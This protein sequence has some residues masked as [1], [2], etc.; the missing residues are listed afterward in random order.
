MEQSDAA[1]DTAEQP[2]EGS[3]ISARQIALYEQRGN[4]FG[5]LDLDIDAGGVTM[6]LAAAGVRRTTLL[7]ALCG[8]MR[9]SSGALTVLGHTDDPH[10]LF[11]Q[12]AV[13]CI[14]E[15]DE[16]EQAVTVK[17]VI[18][19]QRRWNASFFQWVPRADQAALESM[20]G[21]T[22]G[23][24]P[25]PELDA[26]VKYLPIAQQLL[27]K[28]AIANV[29]KPPLLVV[30]RIDDT[31]DEDQKQIL[32]RL[33]ELGQHQ[34]IV[35]GSVNRPGGDQEIRVIDMSGL[36]DIPVYGSTSGGKA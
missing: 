29:K 17:D 4:L 34:S 22:F 2:V 11:K 6:L 31:S 14:D 9:L 24:V 26:F 20:C 35:V 23:D 19:E 25:L 7:L 12:S 15:V 16:I 3:L 5:P 36:S 27:L 32:A 21:E 13:C 33:V 10:A 1:P 8:R 30:G 28:V 18:T